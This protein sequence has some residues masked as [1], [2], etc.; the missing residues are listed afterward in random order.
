MDDIVYPTARTNRCYITVLCWSKEITIK[1][2]KT[3]YSRCVLN[4]MSECVFV[5]VCVCVCVCLFVYAVGVS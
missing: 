1:L 5:C 3:Q 2:K 4:Q